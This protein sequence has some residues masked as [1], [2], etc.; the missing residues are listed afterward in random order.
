MA[1]PTE[2]LTRQLIH[3]ATDPFTVAILAG[4]SSSSFYFFGNLGLA[5]DGTIPATVTRSERARK[6]IS[7]TSAL[8]LWEWMYNRGKVRF[9]TALPR[10]DWD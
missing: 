6:G 7:D 8:N 1:G 2:S 9:S 4:V 10:F 5:L 3:S